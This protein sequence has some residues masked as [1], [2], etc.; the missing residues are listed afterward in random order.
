MDSRTT[1][2]IEEQFQKLPSS[3]RKAITSGD[4]KEKFQKLVQVHKLHLD[5]WETIENLILLTILGIHPP[6]ELPEKIVA[7]SGLDSESASKLVEDVALLIFKPIRE[8][9]ERELGAPQAQEEEVSDMDKL[10]QEVLADKPAVVP[11][12][13]PATP[14]APPPS[15]KIA[16]APAS[17]AYVPGQTSVERANVVDDPYRE[18]PL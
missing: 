6:Q 18:T 13:T 8:E 5:Q 17:G 12:V 15:E 2:T 4:I 9:L 3:V 16:R 10:R 7:E 1:Q 11:A 14:P